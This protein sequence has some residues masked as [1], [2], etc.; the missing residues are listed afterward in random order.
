MFVTLN[1]LRDISRGLLTRAESVFIS[2]DW[3]ACS[4]STTAFQV[5]HLDKFFRQIYR[6]LLI[7]ILNHGAFKT[8]EHLFWNLAIRVLS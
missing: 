2:V 3:A 5:F 6:F 8:D 1:V 7:D 4:M